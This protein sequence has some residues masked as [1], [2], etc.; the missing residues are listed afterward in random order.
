MTTSVK[1]VSRCIIQ[2]SPEPISNLKLQKL[3]Y[4]VQ[5]W[6]L[7]L[8]D[9]LAFYEVIEAWVHGPVVPAAFYEYRH[10]GWNPIELSPET[11]TL[12]GGEVNHID[13]VLNVYGKFTATQLEALTHDESPWLDARAGLDPKAISKAIITPDAM[14][15]FFLARLNG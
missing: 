7:A 4:Y 13:D 2:N 6:S 9:K 3:L 5:G 8:H 1:L 15:T 11:V 14:K 12:P 10:H